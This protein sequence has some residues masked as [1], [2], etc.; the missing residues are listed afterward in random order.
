MNSSHVNHIDGIQPSRVDIDHIN[1]PAV[2]KVFN[3][4]L[5]L[6]SSCAGP[7]GKIHVLR[8]NCRGHV[9]FTSACTRLL[10][11]IF[12]TRPELRLIVA[13]VQ[14]HLAR[15]NDCGLFMACMCLHVIKQSLTG[16]KLVHNQ[17]LLLEKFVC[18]IIDYLQS[19][20]CVIS[21]KA[22]YSNVYVLLAYVRSILK[23]KHMLN[24]TDFESTRL[25]ELVVKTFVESIPSQNSSSKLRHS[26]GVYI[27]GID[28]TELSESRLEYGLLLDFPEIPVVA[29][30]VD[31]TSKVRLVDC[32]RG[33][34]RSESC[35]IKV[36]LFTCSMSGDAEEVVDAVFEVTKQQ[37]DLLECSVVDK[38]M[39]LCDSLEKCSV[40]LVL[41]QKVIHPKVKSV[42]KSKSILFVDRLGLQKIPYLQDLTGRHFNCN[43]SYALNTTVY[44]MS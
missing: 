17:R 5:N 33:E 37:S 44:H 21:V 10:S 18:M 20:E 24:L 13:A 26:D 28:N 3:I 15:H 40:G 23:S 2:Q 4:F 42:L 35:G 36:A 9:T 19:D 16:D 22:D 11:S 7:S 29:G 32:E 25:S 41:C 27:L 31:L 8:N 6:V 14:S 1:S 34:G 30:C 12:V 38:M 39:E 43:M